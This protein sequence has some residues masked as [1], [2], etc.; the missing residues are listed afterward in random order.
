MPRWHEPRF[1]HNT[2]PTMAASNSDTHPRSKHLPRMLDQNKSLYGPCARNATVRC[3]S[4]SS[5]A[6]RTNNKNKMPS[7]C[8]QYE[9]N[10]NKNVQKFGDTIYPRLGGVHPDVRIQARN[11]I[12]VQFFP[13]L[14][15]NG[16]F[17][18]AY[19]Q[20]AIPRKGGFVRGGL[21]R[22][23]GSPMP[24]HADKVHISW[25]ALGD[26]GLVLFRAFLFSLLVE[27]KEDRNTNGK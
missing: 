13:F 1:L 16:T 17:P 18:H 24:D 12:M 22:P 11:R 19:T 4:M 8:G 23:L 6:F 27:E 25:I 7:H 14:I 9:N 21:C 15:G 10:N 26:I 20:P 2:D 3:T 5:R